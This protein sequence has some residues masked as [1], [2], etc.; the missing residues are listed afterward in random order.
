MASRERERPEHRGVLRSLTLP[1]RHLVS[2]SYASVCF[3][4]PEGRPQSMMPPTRRS[5][6]GE[7]GLL[8]AGVLLLAGW[9]AVWGLSLCENRLLGGR[10][11]WTGAWDF[12]GLDFL[13]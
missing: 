5:S 13:N 12:L 7:R 9:A 8:L 4:R 1:A 6:A 2:A 10:F 11:T 3:S